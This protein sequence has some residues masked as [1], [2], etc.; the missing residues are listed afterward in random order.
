MNEEF[1]LEGENLRQRIDDSALKKSAVEQGQRRSEIGQKQ[2]LTM[3]NLQK[4]SL[5][6]DDDRET[7]YARLPPGAVRPANNASAKFVASGSNQNARLGFGTHFFFAGAPSG[8]R[9]EVRQILTLTAPSSS[10][11]IAATL[12]NSLRSNAYKGSACAHRSV[13]SIRHDD[14]NCSSIHLQEN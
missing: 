3:A 4:K 1:C 7:S 12:G 5:I 10:F 8:T 9:V 2:T 11:E 13:G 14:C 6:V